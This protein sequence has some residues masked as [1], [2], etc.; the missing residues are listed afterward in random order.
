MRARDKQTATE[1]RQV[2]MFYRL[3][4]NSEKGYM[5]ILIY[6]GGNGSATLPYQRAKLIHIRFINI[7]SSKLNCTFVN[8][9]INYNFL[10]QRLYGWWS[11]LSLDHEFEPTERLS[12][13]EFEIDKVVDV[14]IVSSWRLYHINTYS[15]FGTFL[16]VDVVF[17]SIMSNKD[18]NTLRASFL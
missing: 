4:K 2:L 12:N 8:V 15:I 9:N 7:N 1:S 6:L 3:R 5:A 13:K 11:P 18:L 10:S 17:Q 14:I 16:N